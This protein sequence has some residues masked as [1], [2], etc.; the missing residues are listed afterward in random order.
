M[1]YFPG[2]VPSPRAQC[3]LISS[4]GSLLGTEHA[5]CQQ[6][7]CSA[8]RHCLES[9]SWLP[10]RRRP[11]A[12]FLGEDCGGRGRG[13]GKLRV[14]PGLPLTPW[15]SVQV[16][17]LW[18]LGRRHSSLGPGLFSL[19]PGSLAE[20]RGRIRPG[21]WVGEVQRLLLFLPKRKSL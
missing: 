20:A 16:P 21:I 8:G 6:L 19:G 15:A 7:G 11:Q 5:G 13:R 18:A 2:P 9:S 10:I 1:P 12:E 4:W 14:E 3:I 17:Q